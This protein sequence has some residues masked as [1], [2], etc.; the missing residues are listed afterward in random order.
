MYIWII[1]ILLSIT[2]VL[3]FLAGRKG[4]EILFSVISFLFILISLLT[5]FINEEACKG[6][7]ISLVDVRNGRY[8]YLSS[9]AGEDGSNFLV[10]DTKKISNS[11]FAF[12]AKKDA[13]FCGNL[14]PGQALW[15]I[16]KTRKLSD[17]V[18]TEISSKLVLDEEMYK[19]EKEF[20][21]R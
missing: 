18:E 5:I 13:I 9:Y 2:F 6:R 14:E 21:F 12:Y 8:I 19:K 4:S 1:L 16:E 11:V 3:V 17:S 10:Q 20:L 15:V 7:P